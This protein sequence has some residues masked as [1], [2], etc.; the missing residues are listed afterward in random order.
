M[1]I[2]VWLDVLFSRATLGQKG[3]NNMKL[4]YFQ[5]IRT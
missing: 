5:K 2:L 1:F 3:K 4:I